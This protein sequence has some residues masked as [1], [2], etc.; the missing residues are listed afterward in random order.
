MVGGRG[1]DWERQESRMMGGRG[2][3]EEV[4]RGREARW[5]E[6][7]EEIRRGK[8]A[9]LWEAESHMI[10]GRKGWVGWR[11]QVETECAV[12]MMSLA[13]AVQWWGWGLA[14]I[15]GMV[16]RLGTVHGILGRGCRGGSPRLRH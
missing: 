14:G 10:G 6:G 4:W 11:H 12:R 16:L 7:G 9:V 15:L 1:R 2:R 3:G 5:W 8:K 13:G